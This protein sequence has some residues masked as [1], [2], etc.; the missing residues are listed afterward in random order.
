[1]NSESDFTIQELGKCTIPSPIGLSLKDNDDFYHYVSD[2]EKV[3]IDATLEGFNNYK[4]N[5][6]IKIF[7]SYFLLFLISIN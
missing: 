5:S 4:K 2:K 3:L 6:I 7:Y 1:M